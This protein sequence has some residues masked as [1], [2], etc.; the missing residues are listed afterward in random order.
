MI[1][2]PFHALTQRLAVSGLNGELAAELRL[3][4]R[5]LQEHH[6]LPRDTERD[7]AAEV[8]LDERQG[9]IHSRRDA[10][11]RVDAAIAYEYRIGLDTDARVH[12]GQCLTRRPMG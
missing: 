5:S 7:V 12:R 8:F 6:Q 3:T 10:G 1:G 2:D 9:Q 4:A 11:R